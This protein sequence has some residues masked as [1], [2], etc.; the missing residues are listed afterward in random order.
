MSEM[1]VRSVCSTAVAAVL[2]VSGSV[3]AAA[4]LAERIRGGGGPQILECHTTR[5]RGHHEGDPQKARDP[6]EIAGLAARDCLV[7]AAARLAALGVAESV[8]AGVRQEVEAEL[9]AAIATAQASPEP[10]FT[11]ASQS[12]Y[13]R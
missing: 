2:A 9:D 5:M 7:N 4:E 13:T 10:D 1:V 6:A 12:V 3:A 11:A 8:L